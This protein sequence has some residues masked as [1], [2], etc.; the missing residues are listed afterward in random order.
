[1][2]HHEALSA[3]RGIGCAF[4]LSLIAWGLVWLLYHAIF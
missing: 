4:V 2:D 3:A 1:M